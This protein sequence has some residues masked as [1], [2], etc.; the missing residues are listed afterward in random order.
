[1]T[2]FDYGPVTSFASQP[3]LN[4]WE[5]HPS[6]SKPVFDLVG[7]LVIHKISGHWQRIQFISLA[8]LFLVLFEQDPP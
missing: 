3:R 5:L 8:S 1:M 7:P 4:A 6:L 2:Y